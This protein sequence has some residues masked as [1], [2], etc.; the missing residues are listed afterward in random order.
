MKYID[1][2]GESGLNKL[3]EKWGEINEEHPRAAYFKVYRVPLAAS[4]EDHRSFMGEYATPMTWD[5]VRDKHGY[6]RYEIVLMGP[7]HR[8]K[9]KGFKL[10]AQKL[11]F[12]ALPYLDNSDQIVAWGR[13]CAAMFDTIDFGQMKPPVPKPIAGRRA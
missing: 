3:H 7:P 13:A 1:G 9:V 6:G 10:I 8:Q 12:K 4:E 5:E 11:V 2:M